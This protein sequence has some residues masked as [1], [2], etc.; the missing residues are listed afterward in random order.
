[1]HRSAFGTL[2]NNES[3]S[4]LA[5]TT[6]G[7]VRSSS[8]SITIRI[9]IRLLTRRLLSLGGAITLLAASAAGFASPAFATP[10]PAGCSTNCS[11]TFTPGEGQMTWIVPNG[12]IDVQI[13]LAGGAGDTYATN[14]GGV[15]GPGGTVATQVGSAY[16]GQTLH[17][18]AGAAGTGGQRSFPPFAPGG[19]GSYVAAPGSFV[20]V[21]GGGLQVSMLMSSMMG[22]P[23][24]AGPQV[25]LAGGGAVFPEQP[26]TAAPAATATTRRLTVRAPSLRRP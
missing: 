8:D 21:A 25:N 26:L 1:M 20:A 14:Q 15:G 24:P 16:D 3:A 13:T 5:R 19:G 6:R 7:T 12:A 17:V 10:A 23:M 11:V 9:L 22:P 18:L 2:S 4:A